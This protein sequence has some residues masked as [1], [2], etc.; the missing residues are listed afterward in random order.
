MDAQFTSKALH[1]KHATRLPDF[2]ESV[3]LTSLPVDRINTN[4][5]QLL[6]RFE[7]ILAPARVSTYQTMRHDPISFLFF[8]FFKHNFYQVETPGHSVRN[9]EFVTQQNTYHP[10]I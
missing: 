7:N 9:S 3:S 8:F 10:C 2:Q 1:S 4:V 6:Q 5:A